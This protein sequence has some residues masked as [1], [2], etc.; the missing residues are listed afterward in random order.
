MHTHTSHHRSPQR[1]PWQLR[2]G[3]ALGMTFFSI[4]G[5]M[6]I[7]PVAQASE[8]PGGT[9]TDP[10]VRAVDIAKP[11]VVR[12]FTTINGQ[13]IVHFSPQQSV[14]FP[15]DGKSYSWEATG[16]GAFIS[17]HGDILTADHVVNP[18]HDSESSQLFDMDAAPDVANYINEYTKPHTPVT[19][20][21]IEQELTSGQL[22][23][24][25][26][27]GT[28]QNQVFLS[29]D[30][31]GPLTATDLKSVPAHLQAP[32]DRIEKA[33]AVDKKDVAIVHV[34]INDTPSV[35]LGDSS[36]IQQQDG[37]TIIGFP[38]AGDVSQSPT[39]LLAT[40]VN[41]IL[42]SSVK[43]TDQGA[44]VIQ[45]AGNVE[46]GDSGGPAL[47]SN[48]NV[49]GVVSFGLSDEGSTNFLQASNSARDLVQSLHLDTTPGPFQKVWSQAFNDYAATAPGH[50]HKAQQELAAI[51]SH[52]PLFLAIMPYLQLAQTQARQERVPQHPTSSSQPRSHTISPL[53]WTILAAVVV[54]VF[55]LAFFAPTMRRRKNKAPLTPT[56]LLP[57]VLP[58]MT[59]AL[60]DTDS[61]VAFGAPT[62]SPLGQV[63]LQPQ[64]S[65][66][67]PGMPVATARASGGLRP[68]H[69]NHPD[70][71]YYSM[72]GE[73]VEPIPTTQDV[74]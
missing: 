7:T 30:Y 38:G 68:W 44:Q 3:L 18:P 39:N 74:E 29:T 57:T 59:Q 5:F 65:G 40:S 60:Q 19:Q 35:Q 8:I 16:T 42:V 64:P 37:L 69:M 24:D 23:S 50:W 25:V 26:H 71:R 63:S 33:S 1:R 34:N 6:G 55:T 72:W 21:D 45:V 52:Y 11:A 67:L 61:M 22:P 2:A 32:I 13:L 9:V 43:T 17:A 36:D 10:V 28:V 62:T 4:I 54:I 46:D 27:Y 53:V 70:A 47:D 49:M 41:E 51:H 73:A 56:I 48:G 58:Q 12:I 14:T 20:D 66:A 31:S 15:L